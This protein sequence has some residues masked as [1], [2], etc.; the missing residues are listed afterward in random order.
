MSISSR[1]DVST[2]Q[3]LSSRSGRMCEGVDLLLKSTITMKKLETSVSYIWAHWIIYESGVIVSTHGRHLQFMYN[4]FRRI[5]RLSLNC[6]KRICPSGHD[7][8]YKFIIMGHL[9][10]HLDAI[11]FHDYL[12]CLVMHLREPIRRKERWLSVLLSVETVR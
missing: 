4:R 9:N 8:R 5:T 6:L 3:Q 2:R 11:R 1:S 10:I 7:T 12:K